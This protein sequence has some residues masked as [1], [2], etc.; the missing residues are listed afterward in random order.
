[1]RTTVDLD[2]DVQAAVDRLRRTKH[3]GLSQ[4]INELARA[5][6]RKEP[7]RK[8]FRQRTFDVGVTIDVSNIAEAL[9]LLEGPDRR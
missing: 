8:P 9:D 4:A 7:A 6:M 5:G 1:M 2:D 3:L